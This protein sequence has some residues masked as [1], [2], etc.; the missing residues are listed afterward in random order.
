[1]DRVDFERLFAAGEV[2]RTIREL[3]KLGE[4]LDDESHIVTWLRHRY[5]EAAERA[6]KRLDDLYM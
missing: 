2:V 3:A 1:M 4:P 5:V 6:Y